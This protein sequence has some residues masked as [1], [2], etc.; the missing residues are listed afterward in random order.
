MAAGTSKDAGRR[1][2]LVITNLTKVGGLV[3]GVHAGL[4]AHPDPRVLAFAAFLCMGAQV[5]ETVL[6]RLIERF[7]GLSP[8]EDE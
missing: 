3:I 8:K 5:S 4:Q 7:F 6:L 2:T 1:S